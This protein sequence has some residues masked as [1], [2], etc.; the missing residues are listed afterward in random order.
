MKNDNQ[1]SLFACAFRGLGI[2]FPVTLLCMTLIG[3]FNEV[4]AELLTWMV[5]SALFGIVSGLVFIK[6][7]LS[8]PLATAIHCVCCLIIVVSACF[9]CGYTDNLLTLITA[10][11][12]VF[13]IIYAIIYLF[14]FLSMK[15]YEKEI[16]ETLNK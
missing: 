2:G 4:I 6:S 15:K 5:A 3:G 1:N 16:N 14:C 9:I 11:L 8:M 13:I 7:D 12:P 10:I